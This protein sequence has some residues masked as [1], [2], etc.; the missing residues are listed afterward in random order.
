MGPG[1]H[2]FAEIQF[3]MKK[4]QKSIKE[5][6]KRNDIG[7]AKVGARVLVVGGGRGPVALMP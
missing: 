2:A 3:E 7:S 1:Y 6:A 5:A 4:I